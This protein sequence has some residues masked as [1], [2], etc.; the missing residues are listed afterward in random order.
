[1]DPDQEECDQ[2]LNIVDWYCEAHHSFVEARRLYSKRGAIV[3]RMGIQ[4]VDDWKNLLNLL[5]HQTLPSVLAQPD[6]KSSGASASQTLDIL[7]SAEIR[8]V[9]LPLRRGS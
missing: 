1:M 6:A 5:V 7:A 3:R 4:R 8:H 9:R 2:M